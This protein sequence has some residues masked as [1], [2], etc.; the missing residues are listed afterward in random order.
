[1]RIS[2]VAF[3]ADES[4]LV[5]SAET[6][7]GLAVYEVKSLLQGNTQ[8]SF[9][10]PTNSTALR[11]LVPNPTTEKAELFAVVTMNGE[12]LM[13]NVKSRDFVQGPAGPIMKNGVSCA[14]WSNR[15]RQITA[16]LGDGTLF[17]M[18]PEGQG[19]AEVPRPS[20][21]GDNEY[22]MECLF[23]KVFAS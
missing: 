21:L 12:L 15:G 3:S 20:Y 17:Q 11:A 6:G 1:M 7:G 14:S 2:Q 19:K 10:L 5:L 13:A 9:Q 16:G 8:P 23:Y 22:G 18:T 4:Y